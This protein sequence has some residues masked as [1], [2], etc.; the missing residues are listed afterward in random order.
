MYSSC[1][2]GIV[3]D[4]CDRNDLLVDPFQYSYIYYLCFFYFY[5]MKV[6]C[7]YYHFS[8]FDTGT[9]SFYKIPLSFI[10]S[11]LKIVWHQYFYAKVMIGTIIFVR[12]IAIT[13]NLLS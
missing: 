11:Y 12:I 3:D 10:H 5:C 8:L 7:E 4:N 1:R 9:N 6:A 13:L 2:L